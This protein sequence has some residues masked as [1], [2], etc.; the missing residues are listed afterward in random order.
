MS[1]CSFYCMFSK[2]K[3]VKALEKALLEH[4]RAIS[5]KS[6]AR[7]RKKHKNAV[8]VKKAR[9]ILKIYDDYKE[10][11]IPEYVGY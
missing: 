9:G 1:I 5:R 10:K 11:E 2:Y 7:Y 6:S 4:D 8:E 3:E